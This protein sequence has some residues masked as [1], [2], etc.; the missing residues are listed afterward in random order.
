MLAATKK[1][2]SMF[3]SQKRVVSCFRSFIENFSTS[4]FLI[5]PFFISS[6]SAS[7]SSFASIS[8]ANKEYKA[9]PTQIER[10]HPRCYPSLPATTTRT[11][12]S[13]ELAIP[14]TAIWILKAKASSFPKNQSPVTVSKK[15]INVKIT[16]CYEEALSTQSKNEVSCLK[17]YHRGLIFQKTSNHC[18]YETKHNY[19]TKY[20]NTYSWSQFVNHYSGNQRQKDVRKWI[21]RSEK[22]Y[23]W[24]LLD[25]C[26]GNNRI[27]KWPCESCGKIIADFYWTNQE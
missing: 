21:E 8:A 13:K 20:C 25:P 14:P 10:A 2:S 3:S 4:T 17:D 18:Y 19:S 1:R 27:F 15:F 24:F 16:V 7:L 12:G 9:S 22:T 11:K 26:T 6:T 23:N 5:W